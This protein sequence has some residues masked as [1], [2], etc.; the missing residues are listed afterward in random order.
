MVVY[1]HSFHC[2]P[3]PPPPPPPASFKEKSIV[4][5]FLTRSVCTCSQTVWI[6]VLGPWP[7]EEDWG[8]TNCV[9]ETLS[10][11]VPSAAGCRLCAEPTSASPC[12]SQHVEHRVHAPCVHQVTA[13]PNNSPQG[14]SSMA[15]SPG[16]V[17]PTILQP[18]YNPALTKS[19]PN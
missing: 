18:I 8:L 4:C 9:G 16:L 12:P 7:R 14:T 15:L 1:P 19:S 11:P 17:L 3:P 6:S 13:R 10:G 5:L 2:P